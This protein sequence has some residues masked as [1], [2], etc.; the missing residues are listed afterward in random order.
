MICYSLHCI[1]I[2]L[3]LGTIIVLK[4]SSSIKDSWLS[5]IGKK[6]P[7][8]LCL[9]QCKGGHVTSKGLR[10]LFRYCED[11]IKVRD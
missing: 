2:I 5:S 10:E 11:S 8:T 9:I 6:Q 4:K 3:L 1:H 7:H